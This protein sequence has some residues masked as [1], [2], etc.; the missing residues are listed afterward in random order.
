MSAIMLIAHITTTTPDF[1][2]ER[3]QAGHAALNALTSIDGFNFG[4]IEAEIDALL[5]VEDERDVLTAEGY[6]DID[7]LRTAGH[8]IVESLFEA[9]TSDEVEI[10]TLG[11]ITAFVSGGNSYGDAPNETARAIFDAYKLP[12]PV[13][14]AM[15]LAIDVVDEN[16]PTV[17]LTQPLSTKSPAQI[18][19]D[20]DRGGDTEDFAID[21]INTIRDSYAL[22]LRDK[23]LGLSKTTIATIERTVDDA[24]ANNWL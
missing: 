11:G 18:F 17:V 16:D 14:H 6:P 10:L 2:R 4:D 20:F 8:Q 22:A 5:P 15:D 13:L 23:S 9:L 12:L 3:T 24:V 1:T 21:V 7:V 19:A